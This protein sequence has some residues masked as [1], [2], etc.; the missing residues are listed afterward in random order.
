MFGDPPEVGSN[1]EKA[2]E[3]VFSRTPIIKLSPPE[4]KM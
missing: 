1:I 3:S 4:L 2:T